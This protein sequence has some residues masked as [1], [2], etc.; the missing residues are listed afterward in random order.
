VPTKIFC[1]VFVALISLLSDGRDWF[2]DKDFWQLYT[3][4]DG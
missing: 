3:S 2:F 4:M 1:D